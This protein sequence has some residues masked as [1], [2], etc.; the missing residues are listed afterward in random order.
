VT[1][2][3]SDPGPG[4]GVSDRVRLRLGA[5]REAGGAAVTADRWAF[6][7]AAALLTA[8]DP[9]TLRPA[10]GATTE[11][12]ALLE[13]IDDCA[14]VGDPT[15]RMW[16]LKREVRYAALHRMS[17]GEE[18]LR[19]IEANGDPDGQHIE[20][21]LRDYLRGTAPPLEEQDL[22]GLSRTLQA[23]RWLA[24]LDGLDGIPS[25]DDAMQTYARKQLFS[26]LEAL[27]G[28]RFH[29]RQS[30][31][32]E[33]RLHVGALEPSTVYTRVR[34]ASKRINPFNAE[35]ESPLMVHGPPGI[36]KSTLLA[37]FVLDHATAES[38]R[39]PFV[40]IDFERPTLSVLEPTSL[41]AEAA[42]QLGIQYPDAAPA[43]E[44]VAEAASDEARRQ[45]EAAVE[46]GELEEV[47]TTRVTVHR[48]LV[49]NVGAEAKVSE[50]RLIRRLVKVLRDDAFKG[51]GDPKLV[52]VL[53]SFE[54]AQYRSSPHLRRLWDM[55]DAFQVAYPRVRVVVSGR[56]PVEQLAINRRPA[57]D[58]KLEEFDRSAAV[59]F[60]LGEGVADRRLAELVAA[61][62]GGNPLSLKLA[63]K[64]AR[65]AADDDA[66]WV[67]DIPRRR[68][69]L[70]RVEDSQ[71]QSRLYQRLL[72]S[73]DNPDVAALAHPGLIL[74]RITP[75]V[76][77]HVMAGPCGLEVP[78]RSRA[79]ALFDEFARQ[80]DLVQR[81]GDVL[82]HRPDVRRDML[83]LV[84]GDRP[85]VVEAL[86]RAAVEH[87]AREEGPEARAEEIY[88]RL[89]LGQ[90]PREV[91]ARWEPGVERHLWGAENEV[92]ARAQAYLA[93]KLLDARATPEA[94]S[95][96]DDEDW[97]TLTAREV[98]D[99]LDQGGDRAERRRNARAAL[100][101]M[102]ARSGWS[103]GSRLY[104]LKAEALE[105][106]GERE[107]AEQAVQAGISAIEDE[108]VPV[109]T[110]VASA[111]L[112]LLLLAAR[113]VRSH[114]GSSSTAD[115]QLEQAEQI[116]GRLGRGLDV[117]GTLLYRM[118]LQRTSEDELDGADAVRR[119]AAR[120]FVETDDDELRQ[121]PG[122]VRSMAV[123]LGSEDPD[124]LNRAIDVLGL[125]PP[126]PDA[127][128]S[129]GHRVVQLAGVDPQFAAWLKQYALRRGVPFADPATSVPALLEHLLRTG[130]LGELAKA[131]VSRSADGAAARAEVIALLP[132]SFTSTALGG[133]LGQAMTKAQW[134][135]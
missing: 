44:A 28:Q 113:L 75:D 88:H 65:R 47:S 115:R 123:E 25:V 97:E 116:A 64:L 42:R 33:L 55:F 83:P 10:R 121:Q 96:A 85:Q 45:R 126:T 21:T 135:T 34:S 76:I 40:Y 82:V 125:E 58:L 118:Q 108:R 77:Q 84:E 46:I 131:L 22:E 36:G 73:I 30:E 31:L 129:L 71:I 124:V 112:D 67:G 91:D 78:D 102:H 48:T 107:S 41:L 19:S 35:T 51:A 38:G 7:E 72:G 68:W 90:P 32:S 66:D 49:H 8:F 120:R 43:L 37:K 20:G 111:L 63:A 13:L 17:G 15:R 127:L 57:K 70:F 74:R 122:L 93:A 109:T 95:Q 105:M 114:D 26:P 9:A 3:L 69:L 104:R 12:G 106:L 23:L 133:D 16:T 89:R 130:R 86:E 24:E 2:P 62:F 80:V 110:A 103:P 60:L 59:A 61:R 81:Q 11:G 5:L 98:E 18:A 6:R 117:L 128:A 53:D 4:A 99:L 92:P 56:A 52:V 100:K 54:Q 27:V 14:T 101:L 87:Y 29:G 94:L 79:Q 39:I 134:L 119:R 1:S 132:E 50:G